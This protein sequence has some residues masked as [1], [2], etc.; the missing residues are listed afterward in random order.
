M[1]LNSFNRP[2]NHYDEKIYEIDKR[3]CELIKERKDI[4][5]NNPGYPPL[6]HIS[7]WAEEFGLYEEL[8]QS[9]FGSLFDD[10]IYKPLVQ[11]TNFIKNIP[12][13]KLIERGTRLFS[14]VCIRQYSNSSIITFNIDSDE[15]SD[16]EDEDTKYTSFELFIDNKYDCRMLNGAGGDGHFHYNFIVSPALPD[17]L[18]EIKLIFK[19][20][21]PP[22]KDTII[23]SEIVIQL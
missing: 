21:E 18:S 5:N 3:I 11:P 14:V 12:V 16:F 13:L 1:Q 22:F 10:N 4:S 15:V 23:D 17:D 9:I 8:L 19:E 20:Y 7:K 6:E 2:T